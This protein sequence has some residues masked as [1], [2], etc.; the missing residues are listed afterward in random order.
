MK[1]YIKPNT[2][3]VNPHLVGS[4]LEGETIGGQSNNPV[5]NPENLDDVEW[6]AK[7][8]DFFDEGADEGWPVDYNPWGTK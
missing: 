3:V 6:S 2:T 5:G 7:G 1:E 8:Q 4:I